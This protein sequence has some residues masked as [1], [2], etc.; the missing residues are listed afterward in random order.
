MDSGR[1]QVNQSPAQGACPP[2][3]RGKKALWI[4]LGAAV[5]LAGAY[6]A[7]CAYAAGVTV[8]YPNYRIN[9]VDVAG[10]TV[11]QAQQAL[12][13]AMAAQTITLRDIDSG[14]EVAQV[15]LWDLGYSSQAFA[16]E[17]QAWMDDLRG[18]GFLGRGWA[19]LA[20][21]AGQSGGGS[22][23][24]D[25][26]ADACGRVAADLT[27]SLYRAPLDA[28]YTLTEASVDITCPWD[29]RRVSSAALKT[30]LL[31]PASWQGH[32][33]VEVPFE[34]LPAQ[35]LTAQEIA[36]ALSGEPRNATYDSATDSIVPEQ[37][38]AEFD[39]A[40]AQAAMDGAQPGKTVSVPAQVT[41]PKVTAEELKTLLFRDVLGQAKTKVS[42]TA[43]RRSNVKLSAAA[44]NGYVLNSGETFSYNDAV[45]PRTAA[46]GYLPAPAYVQGETVD[47]IGGGVCQ[48]SSTL[49]YACLL[50]NLQITERYAHRYVPSYIPWGMD[51]TV[52]WGGLDFKFTNNTD[53]PVKIVTIYENNY[54]TIRLL[55]TNVDGVTSKMTNRVLSS[56][57]WKT[58]YEDDPSLSPGQEVVK[59]TPY[60]G[61]KVET[62]HTL[63]DAQGNVIESHFEASSNY[64][65]RDKVILRGPAQEA[66]SP[67]PLPGDT[68]QTG[69]GTGDTTSSGETTDTQGGSGQ[70]GSQ[71]TGDTGTG[72]DAGQTGDADETVPEN[73]PP[74]IVVLPP[75]EEGAA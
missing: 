71:D 74:T 62:Y 13:Q 2:A 44:F 28:S 67:Q 48:P 63:Y 18:R 39:V 64:K 68:G 25:P 10:L 20:A 33:A 21:L 36:D 51:A 43:A 47:E 31:D 45:G 46:K 19:Y 52:S 26:D 75:Q 24:P 54:L 9:G 69:D 12:E 7:L 27:A 4:L 16:G 61:Y 17:A 58:V 11:E 53:Y 59:V 8:F 60:T 5:V 32:Y 34:V 65:S 29:G 40:A 38:A 22:H 1:E 14:E 41:L 23:W 72:G 37:A 73:P 35:V 57:A 66:I 3:P 6:L 55:G 30:V 70:G 56:T 42:G 15:A 50:S 49:Y